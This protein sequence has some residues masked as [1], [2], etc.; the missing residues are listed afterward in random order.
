MRIN[1]ILHIHKWVLLHF[2]FHSFTGVSGTVLVR[3]PSNSFTGSA[4]SIAMNINIDQVLN[5]ETYSTV[6]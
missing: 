1:Q 2:Y 5:S 6:H 3:I 4:H